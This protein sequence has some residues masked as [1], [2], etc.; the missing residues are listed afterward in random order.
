VGLEI[1]VDDDE[2]KFLEQTEQQYTSQ[3][4]IGKRDKNEDNS[5]DEDD[6]SDGEDIGFLF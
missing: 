5:N 2:I 1:E 4:Q 3:Q 6:S